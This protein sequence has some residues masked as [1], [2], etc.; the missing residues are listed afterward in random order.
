M[1]KKKLSL[2]QRRKGAKT[3]SLLQI[4]EAK[5][6]LHLLLGGSEFNPEWT[7]QI[8]GSYF[9]S[10][11][12]GNDTQTQRLVKKQDYNP[13]KIQFWRIETDYVSIN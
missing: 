7:H 12:Y 5:Y 4:Y 8:C 11:I 13:T 2:L 1:K 9:P 10:H 6:I 3:V